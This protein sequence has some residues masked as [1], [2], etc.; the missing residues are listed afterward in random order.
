[1]L[2]TTMGCGASTNTS[3]DVI[4]DLSSSYKQL[5]DEATRTHTDCGSITEE[6]SQLRLYVRQRVKVAVARVKY[7]ITDDVDQFSDDDVEGD[8]EFISDKTKIK[9][10]T[11]LRELRQQ[12]QQ[13]DTTAAASDASNS[14]AAPPASPRDIQERPASFTFSHVRQVASSNLFRK[15][16]QATLFATLNESPTSSRLHVPADSTS[17]DDHA[18]AGGNRA[19]ASIASTSYTANT[20]LK[21]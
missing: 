11:W 15:E 6:P 21:P 18:V 14:A 12:Q 3:D 17:E 19:R 4:E 20:A 9:V 8:I 13:A 1:M 10:V 16:S 5:Y 7:G 2:C